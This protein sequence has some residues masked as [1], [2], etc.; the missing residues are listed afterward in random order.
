[1]MAGDSSVLNAIDNIF[2]PLRIADESNGSHLPAFEVAVDSNPQKCGVV[3]CRQMAPQAATTGLGTAYRVYLSGTLN[4]FSD[5]H[6]S[7]NSDGRALQQGGSAMAVQVL[8]T[9]T[10]DDKTRP[11]IPSA[12]TLY[13]PPY[14]FSLRIQ[15]ETPAP[16]LTSLPRMKPAYVKG[17]GAPEMQEDNM[18]DGASSMI[19]FGLACKGLDTMAISIG[20]CHNASKRG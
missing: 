20:A 18:A 13:P 7:T 5:Q 19:H 14:E 3:V 12:T 11:A 16:R 6:V 2:A 17:G 1:M 8:E 4:T 9:K 15:R 10:R